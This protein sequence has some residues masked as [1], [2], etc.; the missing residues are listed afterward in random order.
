MRILRLIAFLFL[1]AA[2][3]VGAADYVEHANNGGPMFRTA[4]EWWMMAAPGALDGFQGFIENTFGPDAWD[5]LL[6]TILSW[7]AILVLGLKSM[8]IFLIVGFL[9]SF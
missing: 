8:L 5:P 1:F 9:R 7:P 3:A 2:I 6:T 4:L